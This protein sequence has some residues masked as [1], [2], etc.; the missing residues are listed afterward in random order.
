MASYQLNMKS[1]PTPG[2]VIQ[3]VKPE[4]SLGRD[5]SND[6]VIS[7]ADVSRRHAR[8]VQQGEGYLLEDLGS[9]NGTFINGSRVTA[10]QTLQSGDLIKL[11]EM[12][13]LVYE[14]PGFDAQATV[15]A[16]QHGG[17]EPTAPIRPAAAPEPPPPPEPA[18]AP[19]SPQTY[20]SAEP[21]APAMPPPAATS[22]VEA[23][24]SAPQFEYQPVVEEPKKGKKTGLIIGIGCLVLFCLCVVVVA[25]GVY[26]WPQLSAMFQ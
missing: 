21:E 19:Y 1:G 22:Y 11:G 3:L 26:F 13:E 25:A 15:L 12:V 20:I 10:P 6:I 5:L 24:A 23:A 2:K 14:M 17:F 9:T 4:L 8:L 16:G 7:D 18:A